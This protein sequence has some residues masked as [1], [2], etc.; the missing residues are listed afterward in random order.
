MVNYSVVT[1]H[2]VG[3]SIEVKENI[4]KLVGKTFKLILEF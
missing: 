2:W 3:I 1:I 4:A